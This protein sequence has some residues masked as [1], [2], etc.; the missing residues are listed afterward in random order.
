MGF[1]VT[2]VYMGSSKGEY[3]H[4]MR[5][6]SILPNQADRSVPLRHRAPCEAHLRRPS[7]PTPSR[8]PPRPLTSG[9]LE[10]WTSAAMLPFASARRSAGA[11]RHRPRSPSSS[12]SVEHPLLH[13]QRLDAELAAMRIHPLIKSHSISN[14]P[15]SQH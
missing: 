11:G 13:R 6:G 7:T 5:D 4:R 14:F 1:R 10:P 2:E 8:S 9:A 3:A 12:A 15:E